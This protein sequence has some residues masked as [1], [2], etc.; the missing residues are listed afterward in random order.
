MTPRQGSGE[1]MGR[2]REGLWR[3]AHTSEMVRL[4]GSAMVQS[5][6]NRRWQE[7]GMP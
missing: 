5:T 3:S 6:G 7:N 1:A 4:D 2:G